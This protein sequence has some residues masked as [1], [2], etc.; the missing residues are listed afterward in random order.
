MVS[1]FY[2]GDEDAHGRR[3]YT[4]EAKL[5]Y[6]NQIDAGALAGNQ[7]AV[8]AKGR[9]MQL[10]GDRGLPASSAT[11]AALMLIPASQKPIPVPGGDRR[12]K[13]VENNSPF[14]VDRVFLNNRHFK[15]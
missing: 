2:A 7:D 14:P 10:A 9:A 13:S 4:A 1:R 12:I 6:A 5:R 11:S 3:E 8:E 15:N